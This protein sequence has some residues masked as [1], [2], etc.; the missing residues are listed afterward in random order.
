M[1][2]RICGDTPVSKHGEFGSKVCVL[3]RFGV[4]GL[5]VLG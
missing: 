2:F 4:G 5:M 1:F 3:A